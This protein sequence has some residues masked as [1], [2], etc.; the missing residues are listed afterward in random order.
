M[1]SKSPHVSHTTYVNLKQNGGHSRLEDLGL[2]IL[3]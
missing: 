2:D 3:S 1:R